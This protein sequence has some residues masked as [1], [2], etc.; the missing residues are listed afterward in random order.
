MCLDFV[1]GKMLGTAGGIQAKT[2]TSSFDLLPNPQGRGLINI[3]YIWFISSILSFKCL[4]SH[5]L[6]LRL[7]LA[8]KTHHVCNDLLN[9]YFLLPLQQES[10]HIYLIM[11]SGDILVRTKVLEPVACVQISVLSLN[12]CV[13]S[14]RR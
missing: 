10:D 8:G 1:Q 4:N 2:W 14:G 3:S 7:G 9:A 12:L 6:Q 5:F 13:T 11:K